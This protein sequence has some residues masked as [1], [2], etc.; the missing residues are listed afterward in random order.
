MNEKFI[1]KKQIQ[2]CIYPQKELNI[3]INNSLN[4]IKQYKKIIE[5][6]YL[7]SIM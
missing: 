1:F 3:T 5:K 6:N 4:L 2:F 7:K